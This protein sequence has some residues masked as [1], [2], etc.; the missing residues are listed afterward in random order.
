VTVDFDAGG[1]HLPSKVMLSLFLGSSLF[2]ICVFGGTPP[3]VATSP[4]RRLGPRFREA[5]AL[6][7]GAS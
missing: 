2:H 3:E 4:S 1:D 6:I 7:D 5:P